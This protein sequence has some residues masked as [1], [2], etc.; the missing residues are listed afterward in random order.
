M[1]L[2]QHDW[3]RESSAFHAAEKLVRDMN[4]GGLSVVLAAFVLEDQIW[5]LD[6]VLD[7]MEELETV[8]ANY[9]KMNLHRKNVR[10]FLGPTL[11]DRAYIRLIPVGTPLHFELIDACKLDDDTVVVFD[12]LEN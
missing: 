7:R 10:R 11:L 3:I 6:I 4:I 5:C 1:S 2:M 9:S 8:Q 12:A